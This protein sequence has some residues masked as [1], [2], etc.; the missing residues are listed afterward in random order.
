MSYGTA[1]IQARVPAELKQQFAMKCAELGIKQTVVLVKG[2]EAF[3]AYGEWWE[4]EEA[5]DAGEC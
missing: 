2:I 4:P 1:S 3:V 5:E